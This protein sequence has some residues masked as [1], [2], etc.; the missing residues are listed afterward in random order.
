MHYFEAKKQ[1]NF[2]LLHALYLVRRSW[3]IDS[4]TS[5]LNGFKKVFELTTPELQ[6]DDAETDLQNFFKP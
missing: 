6:D 1:F 3:T 2:N 4:H 5:V